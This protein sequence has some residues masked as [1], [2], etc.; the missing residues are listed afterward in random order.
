[1]HLRLMIEFALRLPSLLW[2]RANR[3]PPFQ[4]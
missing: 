1:M 3:R 4:R 2:R